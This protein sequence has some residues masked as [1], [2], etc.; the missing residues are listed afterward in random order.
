M[1]NDPTRERLE[2]LLSA[3]IDDGLS[4]DQAE[5]LNFL[6]RDDPENRRFYLQYMDV[7]ARLTSP[8]VEPGEESLDWRSAWSVL[9]SSDDQGDASQRS[10]RA[11]ATR[12]TKWTPWVL[13]A[14]SVIGF[15]AFD[16]T[17][18]KTT[19]QRITPISVTGQPVRL[20][21]SA[22]AELFNERLPPLGGTIQYDREYTLVNGLLTLEFP[23]GAQAIL[24]SPSIIEIVDPMR[25]MVKAGRCSLYA[26]EGAEG[27]QIDTPTNRIVDRGTR[28]SVT[29]NDD[30]DAEVQVVEGIAEVEP[31]GD[32]SNM[33]KPVRLS[34][35]DAM[36][37]N[38]SA[39]KEIEFRNDD[40]RSMLPDRVVG[41]QVDDPTSA[42]TVLSGLSIQRGGVLMRYSGDELIGSRAIHFSAPKDRFGVCITADSDEN[43]L[44][45]SLASRLL[46]NAG[47][48]NPGGSEVPLDA[49]PEITQP[50]RSTADTISHSGTMG[51]GVKFD[52]PVL[53]GPG[54]DVVLF[55]IQS[56][57]EHPAGD[58]FHVSPLV[59]RPGLR[60]STVRNYDLT[61]KTPGVIPVGPIKLVRFSSYLRHQGKE[62]ST[63]VETY[64]PA[65]TFYAIATGIDL[66]DLGY[67][68]GDSVG[69]LFFQDASDNETHFD[70]TL[71]LGLPETIDRIQKQ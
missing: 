63:S 54:P 6:L 20:I 56:L 71:I 4:E 30:G 49:A 67:D 13:A 24:E 62:S 69:G 38:G 9:A 48:I 44:S 11:N 60:S 53:N 39:M 3:R 8:P 12:L 61:T 66:S 27:F 65:R 21:S 57:I 16:F 58:A 18:R 46:L 52:R 2:S 26:P 15:L 7:Q 42:R 29:V 14:A 50:D 19:T 34:Q 55:E 17:F 64:D 33:T 68:M 37:L 59:W 40:Y 23:C 25:M 41:Y 51:L 10:H 47:W 1:T 36:R 5:E 28:F 31:L 70:P 45:G 32:E 35:R 43:N 22:G